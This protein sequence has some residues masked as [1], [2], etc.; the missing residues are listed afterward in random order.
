V[1]EDPVDEPAETVDIAEETSA[2]S[3]DSVEEQQAA[4]EKGAEEN[5]TI[6]Q[7]KDPE[8]AFGYEE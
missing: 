6:D 2:E 7:P 8:K 1:T 3:I 4:P 5:P